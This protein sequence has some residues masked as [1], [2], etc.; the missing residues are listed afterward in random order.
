M[1][2][3]RPFWMYPGDARLQRRI[4]AIPLSSDEERWKRLQEALALYRL[5]FGQPRQ[6][7]MLAALQ[8]R[9]ISGRP[10]RIAEIRMDLRPP[11]LEVPPKE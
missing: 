4:M 2:D 11:A 5:A 3:L 6:E 8:R 1:G 10:K 7:D 9:G